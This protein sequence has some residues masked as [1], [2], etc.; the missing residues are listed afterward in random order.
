MKIDNSAPL[1]IDA[2]NMLITDHCEVEECFQVL[3]RTADAKPDVKKALLAQICQALHMHMI[4]EEEIFYPAV[5]EVLADTRDKIWAG[6]IEHDKAKVLMTQ[7]EAMHGDDELFT[8][9]VAE[10]AA[11]IAQHVREEENEIFPKVINSSLDSE[12]L[13]KKMLRRKAELCHAAEA[14]E[15]ADA[16]AVSS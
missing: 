8:A 11:I 3:A 2:I 12:D 9:K 16:G 6:V 4:V 15:P 1:L 13:G 14:E 10:L 5:R 7:L